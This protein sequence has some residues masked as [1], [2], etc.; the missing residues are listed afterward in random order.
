MTE[1]EGEMRRSVIG[2][3][4]LAIV[5]V[6]LLVLGEIGYTRQETALDMGPIQV[7][8]ETRETLPIPPLLSG[9]VL[10]AG[11]ALLVYGL[12]RR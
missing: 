10:A 12:T 5:G 8:T 11:V 9:L 2:G 1:Q 3:A 6:V 4:I 7:E